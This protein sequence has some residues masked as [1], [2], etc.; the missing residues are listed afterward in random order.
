[1][2]TFGLNPWGTSDRPHGNAPAHT[3]HLYANKDAG[4][5]DHDPHAQQQEGGDQTV[6]MVYRCLNYVKYCRCITSN[7]KREWESSCTL[8]MTHVCLQ[9]PLVKV[10]R[11]FL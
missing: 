3:V 9:R 1:M 8:C 5:G 2:D 4:S 6:Q 11:K 10:I 7:R